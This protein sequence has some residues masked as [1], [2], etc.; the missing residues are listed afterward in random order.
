MLTEPED[1]DRELAL[2]SLQANW[3]QTP[4]WITV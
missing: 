2:D 3:E 4:F 1:E